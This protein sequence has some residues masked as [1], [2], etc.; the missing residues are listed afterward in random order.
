MNDEISDVKNKCG[1]YIYKITNTINGKCYI[2]QSKDYKARF[3]GHKLQ[4][5]KNEHD[6]PHLQY[7]W[8]KYGADAFTFEVLE[9][10]EDY[11]ERE[12]Y[13]I[14]LYNSTNES[15][16]YNILEGGENPPV[17]AHST[18][19]VEDV[20]QIQNMFIN[21]YA[22]DDICDKF[23]LV[24]RGQ[25]NKINTGAVWYDELLNYP[26][27]KDNDNEI[28]TEIANSIIYDLLNTNITQ[29]EIAKKYGISR[30]CVT[31]INNGD[32]QKYYNESYTYPLRQN[33]HYH[34]ICDNPE[35]LNNVIFDIK[36]SNLSFLAI[37]KKYE[38][39]HWVIKRVN[40]GKGNYYVDGVDYP[41]RTKVT[42][43]N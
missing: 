39:D 34:K 32:V 33:A 5:R 36:Y 19:S 12:K 11:N 7:A 29:R 35:L 2:G 24:T 37:A 9:F 17:R 18:L 4:L 20:K 23:P 43:Q 27:K 21:G 38:L 8:N 25:I 40:Q 14:K 10:T 16:G 3:Q 41:I 30:T 1:K 42:T 31:A 6:N 26:L 13:Y 28:G 22:L 15:C